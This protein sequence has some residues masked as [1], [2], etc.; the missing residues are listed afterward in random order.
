M[1]LA[2]LAGFYLALRRAPQYGINLT[3]AEDIIFWLIIGGFIG[4]RLYHV[5]SSFTYYLHHPLQSLEVWK[6][7][8]SIYGAVIGGICTLWLIK[9]LLP[10]ACSLFTLL[11]WLAP[12][13]VLGQIIGRFGNFF[14]YELYGYPTNLPW[15]M[16]VP[17]SFRLPGYQN[18][19]YFQPLFLYEVLANLIILSLLLWWSSPRKEKAPEQVTRSGHGAIRFLQRGLLFSCEGG[20]AFGKLSRVAATPGALFFSYL[21]LYNGVR[22]LLEFIRIDS[23]YFRGIRINAYISLLLVLIAVGFL[24]RPAPH[25]QIP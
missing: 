22:F 21:L 3:D 9:K 11:D 7:G 13:L 6:G 23:T 20:W 17:L 2:V 12:S 15:K 1:A 16:F 19:S 24:M 14:N 8:L 18:F 25:D 10:I 5:A 4:A